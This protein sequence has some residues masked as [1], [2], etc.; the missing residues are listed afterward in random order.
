MECNPVPLILNG[1]RPNRNSESVFIVRGSVL[2]LL[3]LLRALAL[4]PTRAF[5]PAL[6]TF[7]VL[8]PVP[9]L[10]VA[11]A[12]FPVFALTLAFALALTPLTPALTFALAPDLAPNLL[13]PKRPHSP[14]QGPTTSPWT[15]M[16][17][18]HLGVKPPKT[19]GN[20]RVHGVGV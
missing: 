4:A 17:L 14:D 1:G 6:A 12:L 5:A 7:V 2:C 20:F 16:D 15:S 13:I 11:P 3:S 18:W 9:A 8:A 10:A 19:D